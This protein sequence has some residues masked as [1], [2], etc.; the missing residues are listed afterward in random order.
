MHTCFDQDNVEQFEEL[1]LEVGDRCRDYSGPVRAVILDWAGTTV[2]YGCIGPTEV[3][4]RAFSGFGV[5]VDDEEIRVFMGLKKIDHVRAM[6]HQKTLSGRWRQVHGRDPNE[7]D[8][9]DIYARI[10]PLMMDVVT[11]HAELIPGVRNLVTA[12]RA[13]DIR[14]GST[15]GYSRPMV[16]RL[17]ASAAGQGYKPD[18]V[19]CSTEVSEGRPYPW[20]CYVNAMT[21]DVFPM[22]AMIKIGD[23]V[24]D[25]EE[26]LN[27]GMWTIGLTMSGNEL[28]LSRREAES[29][30]PDDLSSSLELIARR[31]RRAGAHY[32]ARGVW[33]VLPLIE[34]IELRLSRG[35]RP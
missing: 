2:D 32:T 3:F 11:D 26:G 8:V 9:Q 5:T 22:S 18:T 23:T 30:A 15:T 19:V 34:E 4:R 13:K 33:E 25:I 12:L 28:G 20:M 29:L 1:L 31:F 14:I 6:T 16:E 35:V 24:A 17:M 27:A 21:L 7:Q 10:E